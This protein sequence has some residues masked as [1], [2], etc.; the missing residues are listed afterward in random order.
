MRTVHTVPSSIPGSPSAASAAARARAFGDA[1]DR[2]ARLPLRVHAGCLLVLMLVP[3]LRWWPMVTETQIPLGDEVAYFNAFELVAAGES[4]FEEPDY[5]YP[6]VFAYAGAWSLVHLGRTFTDALLQA[7]NLLGLAS[8]IWCSMAWLSWTVP[9]RLMAG[10]AFI[11]LAPQ[12]RYS[13]E[14]NNFSLAVAG[15]VL[16]GLLLVSRRP[17]VAGL[18]LGS[19]VALKPVAPMA[20]GCLLFARRE[21]HPRRRWLA[22]AAAILVAAGL[23]LLFPHLDELLA[24]TD[25]DRVAATIS[26]HRFP[27]LFGFE[28]NALWISA[29]LALAALA[30][31]ARHLLGRARFLCFAVT[32]SVAVTPLVWSHTL[33]VLLPLEVLALAVA[34]DRWAILREKPPGSS[35]LPHWLEPALVALAVAAIQ[36]SAG[37]GSIGDQSVLLQLFGAGIPAVAPLALLAYLLG[38]TEPF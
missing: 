5:L 21:G 22:A 24:L 6:S 13:V 8:A 25:T 19:S 27:K 11:L 23:V 14:F 34:A 18:L 29:P 2:W 31:V 37:A 32:A 35:L 30:V 7:L 10:A 33:V 4:P 3:L 9:R 12:V 28:V 38:T 26:L 36:L 15:M 17:L 1:F 16:G 20:V